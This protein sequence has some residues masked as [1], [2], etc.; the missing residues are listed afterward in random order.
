MNHN[1]CIYEDKLLK[2]SSKLYVYSCRP[3]YTSIP[4][5][6]KWNEIFLS[7]FMS[8]TSDAELRNA[9][10]IKYLACNIVEISLKNLFELSEKCGLMLR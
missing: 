3:Y 5:Q 9:I 1:P 6:I 8:H 7:Y 10:F 4:T 2:V